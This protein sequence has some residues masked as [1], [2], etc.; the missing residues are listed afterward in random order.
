MIEELKEPTRSFVKEFI[1][2]CYEH[3]D[4]VDENV[5]E[6][7]DMIRKRYIKNAPLN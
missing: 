6:L 2:D 5:I 1:K 7:L 3:Q 4:N